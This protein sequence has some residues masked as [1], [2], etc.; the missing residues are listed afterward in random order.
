MKVQGNRY[1]NN[2]E[3]IKNKVEKK[4]TVPQNIISEDDVKISDS[5]RKLVETARNKVSDFHTMHFSSINGEIRE[6]PAEYKCENLF[7]LDLKA[8]SISGEQSAF[9][10]CLENQ[11]EVF[12]KWLD[13]NASEYLTED[14]MKDLKEKIN[15]MTA[16]V[17]SLNAQEGYR[18][19]SY[20]SVFLLSASEVGLRKV[21]EMYVPE[22]F[23]AGFSDMIDEYVHFNDSARNSIMEKMTPDYMVV[24]IGSKTESYKYK[25]EIIS[26]ETA[27][28]TNEKKEISGICNQFL[29][30]KTDQKLF[31]N[32]M[33]DR[34]NDYYGSR[35]EL[36][37]QPDAVEGRV[38]NMLDKLQHMFGI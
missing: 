38:N 24:G 26:D 29:N 33:K 13:E 34:L 8:T 31:C 2:P 27:F 28:Y 9:E 36:R 3:M 20:E 1:I 17:D 4:T 16:D 30:G 15:A 23:Q 10:G 5:A 22:Q 12:G 32:E 14:E 7:K 35:Y 11:S 19:T 18:G 6:I 37:N 21:N 25:S